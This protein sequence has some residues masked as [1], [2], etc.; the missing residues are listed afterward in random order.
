[1]TAVH[2][3]RP[4]GSEDVA[5]GRVFILAAHAIET[6]KILLMS[7]SV[8]NSSDQVGRNLMDHPIQLSW[9]LAGQPVYPQ[10]GPLS[11]SGIEVTRD[12]PER[13]QRSAFRPEIANDGWRFPVGDPITEA[14]S[15]IE[16][17]LGGTELQ[18]EFTHHMERELRFA[19]LTEDLPDPE[20]RV[21]LASETDALGLP[22]P[23]IAYRVSQYVKDGMLA[24]RDVHEQLFAGLDATER[25]HRVDFEGA[26]HLMGT[27][28]MGNDPATSV[29]NAD[30]RS[31]DHAN[32]FLLGSGV[33]PTVG[34]ANPTLTIAAL[35]LRATPEIRTTVRSVQTAVPA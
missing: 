2:F 24:A 27:Y 13:A 33:F 12:G 4:D 11:T 3:K 17:G 30:Q 15:F 8:A 10:R 22:R 14:P 28:R 25:N 7:G 26:G 9:A 31:H 34:T 20:N 19:S 21:T 5:T 32:L 23:R 16:R 18:E 1:V 6:V 35:A 29:V